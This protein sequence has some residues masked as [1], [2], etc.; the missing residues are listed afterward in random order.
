M[1]PD[2]DRSA[3]ASIFCSTRGRVPPEP[4]WALVNS[5]LWQAAGADNAILG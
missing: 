1:T 4:A 3:G 5:K 2:G